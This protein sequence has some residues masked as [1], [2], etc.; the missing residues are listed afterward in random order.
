MK[1]KY[2]SILGIALALLIV[3]FIF[4]SVAD[5]FSLGENASEI[6]PHYILDSTL[7]GWINISFDGLPINSNFID[8]LS[9]QITLKEILNS[10]YNSNYDYECDFENCEPKI[11]ATNPEQTKEF[12]LSS[13]SEKTILLKLEGVIENVESISFKVES[14]KGPSCSNQV[15]IDK[16]FFK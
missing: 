11:V 2:F 16:G 3:P 4:A 15:E 14:D 6:Y 12:P 9:N 8:S 1:R 10:N 13:V 7:Q 5:Q